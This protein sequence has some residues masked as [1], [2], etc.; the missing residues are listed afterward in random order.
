[1]ACMEDVLDVYERPADPEVARL[2]FDELPCQLLG[3]VIAPLPMQP[4]RERKEDYEYER[5]GTCTLLLAYDLDRENATY[6]Y[7]SSVP[8]PITLT[9]W[10]GLSP[11]ITPLR[12]RFK[13]F[14]IT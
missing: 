11:P 6:R 8:K 10:T 5:Q 13:S 9:L 12:R 4:G 3:D 7:V 1:L 2:G 14:K